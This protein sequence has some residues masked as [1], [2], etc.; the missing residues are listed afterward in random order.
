MISRV[1]FCRA[2]VCWWTQRLGKA[3]PAQND[4]ET[5]EV[6]RNDA[7]GSNLAAARH[8]IRAII[9]A[10]TENNEC[11]EAERKTHNEIVRLEIEAD[12]ARMQ[13]LM[14]IRARREAERTARAAGAAGAAGRNTSTA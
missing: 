8:R 3:M 11:W 12:R 6:A 2:A 7:I 10:K 1:F 9:D 14:A 5:R 4:P 13:G